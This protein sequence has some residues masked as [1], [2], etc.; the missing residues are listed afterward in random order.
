MR[1]RLH[2]LAVLACWLMATP[3]CV[4]HHNHS[5]ASETVGVDESR[6][7]GPPPHAPAHGHRR[8]HGHHAGSEL[9]LEFDRDLGV[10]VVIG[11]RDHYWDGGRYLRW[12]GERWEASV[13][14]EGGWVV[15]ASGADVPPALRN[16][17][18]RARGKKHGHHPA[19]HGF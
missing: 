7:G 1:M 3:G 16:K 15:I 5:R 6:H 4:V 11:H 10:H 8:K 13:A 17:H 19:K 18:G 9:V 12:T 2:G 14:F